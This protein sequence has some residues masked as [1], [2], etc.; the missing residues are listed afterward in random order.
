MPINYYCSIGM[1]GSNIQMNKNQ[2]LQPVIETGADLPTVGSSVEGQMF[3][4]TTAGDKT[5]YFFNG[6]AW[7][8]MDGT[9]SGVSS[10]VTTDGT[11]IDL[12]PTTATTGAVTVT[13]DLSAT[14]LSGTPAIAETQFL[15]GDNTF[16]IPSGSYT[17][18]KL[19]ANTGTTF[20]IID[21]ATASFSAPTGSGIN[22]VVSNPTGNVGLLAIAVDVNNLTTCLLYT[23]PSPRD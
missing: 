11:F 14:G 10:V 5:M 18:W 1:V 21:G 2:L 12:T 17:S 8:P 19:A 22:T 16:A 6:T 23:S 7:V 3:F 9:G 13:A 15:R 4:D 20:G